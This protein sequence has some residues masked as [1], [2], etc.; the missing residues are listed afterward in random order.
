MTTFRVLLL[1]AALAASIPAGAHAKT[2]VGGPGTDNLTGNSPGGDLIVGGGGADTL[3]GGPG[4]DLIFGVRSANRISGGQGDN[5]IEGGTG[6]DKVTAGSGNNTVYTGSGHDEISLGDGNNYVDSGGAPDEITVGNGNNVLQGGSGGAKIVAGNGNNIV[7]SLANE[8]IQLGGGVNVVWVAMANVVPKIDCGGNPASTLWVNRAS[9]P[10]GKQIR[11]KIGDGRIS[12][13]PNVQYFD[14]D[15]RERAQIAGDWEVFN[16]TGTDGPDKIFGGHGGG[17]IDGKGGDNVLWADSRQDTGGEQAKSRTTRITA[18]N[19]NNTVYGGRGTNF[20]TLG[21]GDNFVRGGAWHNTIRVGSGK[22]TIRLQ[23]NGKNTVTLSGGE[24][25]VESFVR[26]NRTRVNCTNGAKGTI[27]TGIRKV[28]SNCKTVVRATSP[29]GKQLQ[30][31]A[32]ERIEPSDDVPA[33]PAVPGVQ[34]GVTR[35]TVITP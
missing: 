19:G 9:D 12:G 20:I 23:G 24:S 15:K 28:K 1:G 3:T 10:T 2:I 26:N 7:Y 34:A 27:I 31:A 30:V 17:K 33:D 13:C 4:P 5:Y 32:I 22:N 8:T 11:D 14:G 6:D 25:I 29:K 16:M 18:G 35:P 21:S